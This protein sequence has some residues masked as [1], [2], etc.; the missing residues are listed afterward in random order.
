MKLTVQNRQAKVSVVPLAATLVIK[1][2]KE[3]ERDRKKMKNIKH[4]GDIS[5]DDVVETAKVTCPRS[6]A[7]DLSG[8]IKEV[9]GTCVSM[10]CMVDGKDLKDLLQEN[11]DGDVE[12]PLD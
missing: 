7:K 6:M 4:N 8:T 5:L 2:L 3:L 12:V 10:G 1:A 9:L 11:S